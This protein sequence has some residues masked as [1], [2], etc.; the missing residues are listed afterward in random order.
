MPIVNADASRW[1][2]ANMAG[3]AHESRLSQG[4]KLY[5]TVEGQNSGTAANRHEQR[6]SQEIGA[7]QPHGHR[8][9]QSCTPRAVPPAARQS[10]MPR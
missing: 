5:S 6:I 1:S 3:N 2:N 7:H 10:R 8:F 4:T 9:S